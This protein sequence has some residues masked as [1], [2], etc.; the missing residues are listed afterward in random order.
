M[1][2]AIVAADEEDG[3]GLNNSL[4]WPHKSEDLQW[5]KQS[6]QKAIVVM[7]RKTWEDPKMPKPLPN[8]YNIVVSSSYIEQGPNLVVTLD[9]LDKILQQVN[10]P[11]WIIGGAKLLEHCLPVCKELWISRIAGNYNCDTYLPK[12]KDKFWLKQEIKSNT[13]SIEKWRN[14]EAIP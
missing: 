14:Y 4:P 6:T 5:F 1:I 12:Y 2:R 13:L 11:I 9:K 7:G 10:K 3:I 8:R